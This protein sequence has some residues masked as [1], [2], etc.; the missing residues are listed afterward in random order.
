MRSNYGNAAWFGLLIALAATGAQARELDCTATAISP[1]EALEASNSA[2]D[3]VTEIMTG[4]TSGSSAQRL[5]GIIKTAADV[6]RERHNW[7]DKAYSAAF[8]HALGR[9]LEIGT[10]GYGGLSREALAKFEAEEF[11]ILV[12]NTAL[13]LAFA[14]YL[15]VSQ[16]INALAGMAMVGSLAGMGD[17]VEQLLLRNLLLS[18]ALQRYG[19]I[20]MQS[21][22]RE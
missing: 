7:D 2:R 17:D 12:W 22:G 5:Y 6:C 19:P 13:K 18:R 3:L 20:V 10:L 21:L 16:E 9:Q 1:N 14:E 8:A 15:G 4:S 11:S